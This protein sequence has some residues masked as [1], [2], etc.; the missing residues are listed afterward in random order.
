MGWLCGRQIMSPRRRRGR[1]PGARH[2]HGRAGLV[3][4]AVGGVDALDRVV[5]SPTAA[6]PPRRRGAASRRR[7]C[8]RSR[9][10]RGARRCGRMTYCTGKRTS[11]RL[12]SLAVH[13]LEV[14]QQRRPLVPRHVRRAVDDVVAVE[15]R[16]RD[17]RHVVEVEAGG[18]LGE[19]VADLL[20][21]VSVV[22]DEVHLVDADDEVGHAEQRHQ[23]AVPAGLLE[24]AV[25]GVDEHDRQV[26]RR[27]AGDHVA[28]VLHVA[29]AVGDDE[30]AGRAWRSSGRRRR[31]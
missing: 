6:R 21:A 17:E 20:E 10:S 27:G 19:L 31:S 1:R 13:G 25:A 26:G 24:D 12:S 16:D 2:G 4:R 11:M 3:D 8:R 30:V 28:R 18:E 22:V 15:R 23:Q 9:G 29:G 14:V 5:A 7:R